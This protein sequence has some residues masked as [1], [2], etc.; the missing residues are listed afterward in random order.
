MLTG[1]ESYPFHMPG[2][3]RNA[4]FGIIGSEI[5]ITEIDGFDNLNSP[6]GVLRDLERSLADLYKARD[7]C[8]S[9][10]GA[11]GG[12]FAAISAV[13]NEGDTIIIARN[14]HKSVYNACMINRLNVVYI[15]PEY[16]GNYMLY[17]RVTQET[18]DK[19]L[20]SCKNVCAVVITSPTYDGIVSNIKCD[21]PLIIDSA[22]GAHFGFN[23]AFPDRPHGD[24]IIHSLHKT[25]PALTQTA[26]V[27]TNNGKYIESVRKYIHIYQSS[28]PSYVLLN[29]VDRCADYFKNSK[30]S[31]NSFINMLNGFYKELDGIENVE[32]LKN[33]DISRLII[34]AK[35]YTGMELAA[36]L[37]RHGIEPEGASYR[38]VT[39][40]A[41]VCDTQAGFDLLL[42]ALKA[43]DK[44]DCAPDSIP[45]PSIPEKACEAYEVIKTEAAELSASA[46]RICGEFVYAYPPGSPLLVPGEII[47]DDIIKYIEALTEAGLNII[48]D[49]NLLPSKILTKA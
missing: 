24:I 44:R 16:D 32:Y 20:S 7:C 38:Y 12:I 4:Q 46:G 14:C 48:S 3:K 6:S 5:D 45:L 36:H 35:G 19:A 28:S 18:V 31:F 8:I 43:L 25:L 41:T 30:E 23:V 1:I 42:N 49:S 47:S 9:V 39:L 33:D 15:E 34:S 37:R 22:H 40:I 27:L 26:A 29:S 17:G 2:H 21:A 11:T 10:N 13:S